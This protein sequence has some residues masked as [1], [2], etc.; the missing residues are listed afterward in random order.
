MSALLKFEPTPTFTGVGKLTVIDGR[1]AV[2]L[3]E[4]VHVD[5][6]ELDIV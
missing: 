6:A 5:V 1:Q 4:N 3:P 2:L